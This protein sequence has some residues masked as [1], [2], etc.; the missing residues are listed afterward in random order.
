M[1]YNILMKN[2]Q[3]IEQ[4]IS[5]NKDKIFKDFEVEEIGVFGSYVRGEATEDSDIDILISLKKNHRVG[6]LKF[7]SL[8]YFLEDLL[9]IKVDLVL[10]DGIKRALKPYILNEVKYL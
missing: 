8:N 5:E 4:K 3:E 1:L 9:N 6:M 2:L 7:M 10:K